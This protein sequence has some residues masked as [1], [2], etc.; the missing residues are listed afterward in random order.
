MALLFYLLLVWISDIVTFSWMWFIVSLL[1]SL[2]NARTIYRYKYTNNPDLVDEDVEEFG[3]AGLKEP[4][5]E[6]DIE[7]NKK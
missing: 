6:E 3:D 2:G 7:E 5:I 4:F 1:F